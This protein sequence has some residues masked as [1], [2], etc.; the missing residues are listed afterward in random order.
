MRRP[1]TISLEIG[2]GSLCLSRLGAGGGGSYKGYSGHPSGQRRTR[3]KH[4]SGEQNSHSRDQSGQQSPGKKPLD[5]DQIVRGALLE[6]AI[7]GIISE[8]EEEEEEEEDEQIRRHWVPVS[9][10]KPSDFAS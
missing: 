9:L 1:G 8:E 4:P 7:N 2:G 5:R 6:T 10:T 3:C